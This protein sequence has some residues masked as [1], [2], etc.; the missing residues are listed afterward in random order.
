MRQDRGNAGAHRIALAQRGVADAHA[1]GLKVIPWTFRNE[2]TFM[3]KD[4][5]TS[6]TA[7]DY[8]RAIDSRS[9]ARTTSSPP[10]AAAPCRRCWSSDT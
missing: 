1:V 9:G 5:Q 8:G 7:S 6:G 3:A 10:L 2:N 4:L